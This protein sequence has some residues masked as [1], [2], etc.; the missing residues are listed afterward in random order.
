LKEVDRSLLIASSNGIFQISERN[1]TVGD[2][3]RSPFTIAEVSKKRSYILFIPGKESDQSQKEP[4]RIWVGT[5]EG[6]ITLCPVSAPL[7]SKFLQQKVIPNN[8]PLENSQDN[9]NL[10]DWQSNKQDQLW[11]RKISQPNWREEMKIDHVPYSIRTIAEDQNGDLWLGTLTTGVLRVKQSRNNAIFQVTE[12]PCGISGGLPE[13]ESHVFQVAGKVR[14]ATA[15][16][17]FK[18]RED[19]G[20][21]IPEEIFGKEF[22]DG[23]RGV[24]RI[25]EDKRGDVWIHSQGRNIHAIRQEDG[26]FTLDRM[27]FLRLPVTQVNAIYLDPMTNA[28]WFAGNQGLYRF[29]TTPSTT[30][31]KGFHTLIREIVI[32][33]ERL[34]YFPGKFTY[35]D[36][37]PQ[38]TPPLCIPFPDRNIRFEFAALFFQGEEQTEYRTRLDSSS[39][40]WSLWTRENRKDYTNLDIGKHTFYVQAR[41][42]FGEMG[43]EVVYPFEILPPWYKTWWAY[44][45]YILFFIATLT[46]LSKWRSRKLI[47]E[48]Q[49][50]E[51]EVGERT[52]EINEKNLQ[53]E[54]QTLQLKEQS[55]QLQEMAQIKSR[56]FSNISHEF[57]TPLTL[58]IGPL[59]QMLSENAD[60]SIKQRVELM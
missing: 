15:R 59:E 46:H 4:R 53:L 32:N 25:L 11:S 24:F 34:I 54:Q 49:K 38:F 51:Q 57:R 47:R 55:E 22:A 37:N 56:F 5:E 41:N 7:E 19:K 21:F 29:D 30:N 33:D 14:F 17:I 50:L 27:P 23:S 60:N 1:E 36:E 40:K 45:V 44:T 9:R 48:K 10:P 20:E 18:F 3:K 42:V 35:K 8:E 26:S 39:H 28:A 6:L 12:F 52:K 2:Q 31:S 58:I 43:E 13:G 16:G